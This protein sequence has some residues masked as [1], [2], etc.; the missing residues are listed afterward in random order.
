MYKVKLRGARAKDTQYERYD[1]VS[2]ICGRHPKRDGVW[3]PTEKPHASYKAKRRLE[4]VE[5][6]L[7]DVENLVREV[8]SSEFSPENATQLHRIQEDKAMAQPSKETLTLAKKLREDLAGTTIPKSLAK[9]YSQHTRLGAGRLGLANWSEKETTDCL[10]DALRLLEAAFAEREGGNEHW[11]ES[12][13]RAG[14]ILEWLSHP[15]LNADR[16]PTRFLAAAAY[17]LAGYRARS[18]GLLNRDSGEKVARKISGGMRSPKGS[19]TCMGLASLFGTWMVQHLN[20][21]PQCLALLASSS[22]G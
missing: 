16:H 15:Q 12:M 18:S 22:L 17:Q 6:H 1:L 8:Y 2:Y 3:L 20:P 10:D 11:R 9:L 13:R 4:A 19:E 14:E 21:F 7:Y 5:V